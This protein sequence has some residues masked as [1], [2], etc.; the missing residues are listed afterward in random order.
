LAIEEI[1]ITAGVVAILASVA[2]GG[3][4]G[5]GI[6][7]P[8]LASLRR[9]VLLMIVGA[10]LLGLGLWLPQ[11]DAQQSQAAADQANAVGPVAGNVAAPAT[12]PPADG[13]GASAPARPEVPNIVGLPF[14]A[15]RQFLIQNSWA[16][17]NSP[18]SPMANDNLGL[19]GR[20]VMDAGYFETVAC[21]G[22]AMAPC[23][24]RYRHPSGAILQVVAVGE[25]VKQAIVNDARILDCSADPKPD[26]CG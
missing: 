5:F 10:G 4:K 12:Q 23:S 6:E 20:E 8:L 22:A 7:V 17:L 25:D 13:P 11:R 19:R 26:G 15:A 16:P 14:A 9:Q 3:L 24:F 2:G 18:S 21:S 1:L